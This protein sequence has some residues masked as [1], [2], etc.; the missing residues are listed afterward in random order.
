MAQIS[1]FSSNHSIVL[2]DDNPLDL[3]INQKMIELSGIQAK[4]ELVNGG[5]EA[6]AYLETCHEMGNYPMLLLLDINMPVLSG[7]EVLNTCR[8]KG[9]LPEDTLVIMLTS[10]V[11]PEDKRLAKELNIGFMEKPLTPM[12]VLSFLELTSNK[13]VSL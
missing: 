1:S 8:Q 11:H 2:V 12:K 5:P 6:V 4:V 7:F 9:Y 3:L 13:V 10:S